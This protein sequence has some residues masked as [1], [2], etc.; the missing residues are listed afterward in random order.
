MSLA[1]EILTGSKSHQEEAIRILAEKS[2]SRKHFES[3]TRP[4]LHAHYAGGA[5]K[6][7]SK[8]LRHEWRQLY[9]SVKGERGV[10][11]SSVQ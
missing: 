7:E 10:V 3:L 8:Q 11:R 5:T 9:Q 4:L 2:Y 1:H 6:E